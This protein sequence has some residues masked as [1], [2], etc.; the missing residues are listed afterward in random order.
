[1][2]TIRRRFKI[3]IGFVDDDGDFYSQ[4]L[5]KTFIDFEEAHSAALKALEKHAK[6]TGDFPTGIKC[7]TCLGDALHV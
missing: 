6:V 7:I 2:E 1:M 3:V 5:F 4:S